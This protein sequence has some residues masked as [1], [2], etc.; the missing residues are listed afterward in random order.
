MADLKEILTKE[1]YEEQG[2]KDGDVYFDGKAGDTLARVYRAEW[3]D[4]L[5]RFAPYEQKA[6][7][8][9]LDENAAN[10]AAT[11][12]GATMDAGFKTS[13]GNLQRDRSRYGLSLSGRES[14]NETRTTA[15]SNTAAKLAAMNN[16]RMHVQDQQER[17]LSGGSAIGLREELAK[18]GS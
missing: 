17:I 12:A 18:G 2:Y 16:T 5:D 11:K 8:F 3:Q 7:A 13:A 15:G 6:I 10:E 14:A 1:F 9:A 4:Y